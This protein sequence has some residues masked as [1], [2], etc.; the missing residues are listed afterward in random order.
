MAFAISAFFT[1]KTMKPIILSALFGTC[2]LLSCINSDA[3]GGLVTSYNA[4]LIER[5]H[6]NS[7]G[8]RIRNF[9]EIIRQDLAN[10]YNFGYRNPG[11]DVDADYFKS[12]KNRAKLE[13]LLKKAHIP[14]SV[15]DNIVSGTPLVHVDMYDHSA[16]VEII[17]E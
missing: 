10:V 4:Q 5:D 2:F 16:N 6:Y 13:E 17:S 9:A 12:E 14:Q 11:L 1:I 7:D 15:R 3:Q 8:K